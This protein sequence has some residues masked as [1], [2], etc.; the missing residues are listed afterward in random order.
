MPAKA[1]PAASRLSKLTAD[2]HFGRNLRKNV[3]LHKTRNANQ[4]VQ[5]VSFRRQNPRWTKQPEAAV[6]TLA[7]FVGDTAG[8]HQ[9]SGVTKCYGLCDRV[10]VRGGG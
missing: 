6:W 2:T 7:V 4:L 8:C 9:R 1:L 3:Y 5:E 10:G